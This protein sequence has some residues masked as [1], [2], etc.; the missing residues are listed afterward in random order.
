MRQWWWLG[1][2][3]LLLL[4]AAVL[5]FTSDEPIVPE[6]KEMSLPTRMRNDERAR[7]QQRRTVFSLAPVDDAGVA[8]GAAPPPRDPL[9]AIMPDQVKYVAMVWEFN[10]LVNSELG[11]LMLDCLAQGPDRSLFNRMR[12]A[13]YDPATMIDRVGFVDQTAVITG[14]LKPEPWRMFT[15]EPPLTTDYGRQGKL[16]EWAGK[17]GSKQFAASWGSAMMLLGESRAELQSS[18]DRLESPP[19]PHATPVLSGDQAYGE[20]YG[21]ITSEA[22]AKV[23]GEQDEQLAATFRSAAKDVQLHA[24]VDHDVGLVADIDGADATRAEELRRALGGALSLGRMQAQAKGRLDEAQLLDSASVKA[25]GDGRFRMQA[26][27]PYD[28]MKK[29]FQGCVNRKRSEVQTP[30][31]AT[32]P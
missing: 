27:L 16:Y 19:D 3:A 25:A 20:M 1:A 21:V 12:D 28:Y 14:A 2:A 30:D 15:S 8:V 13:G 26:G 11:P 7:N 32:P 17:D 23:I 5:M 6:L 10:A 24:D 18:L 31:A 29:V 9:L 22:I 4:L